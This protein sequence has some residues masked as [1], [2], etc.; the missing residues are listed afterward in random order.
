MDCKEEVGEGS[1]T[2]PAS[3]PAVAPRRVAVNPWFVAAV[4]A[5]VA[6]SAVASVFFQSKPEADLPE[7]RSAIET[8]PTS[9]PRSFALSPDGRQLAFVATADGV[10]RLWVRQLASTKAQPLTVTEGGAA[11]TFWSPDS[12]SIG[13]FSAGKLRTIDA[14]G[15]SPRIVAEARS[16]RGGT[17]NAE[18]V[19]LFAP[20]SASPLSRVPASGG[21]AVA[22]TK[23]NDTKGSHR[24][25]QFLP[26]GRHFLF[27]DEGFGTKLVIALGTLGSD[28]GKALTKADSAGLYMPPGWVLWVRAGIL[29]ARRL[30]IAR[31]ELTGDTLTVADPVTSDTSHARLFSVSETGVVTYRS[32]IP[33]TEIRWFD[34]SG[35][36]LGAFAEPT[37]DGYAPSVG[38]LSPDGRRIASPATCGARAITGSSTTRTPIAS[39]SVFLDGVARSGRPTAGRWRSTRSRW[40]RAGAFSAF[41]PRPPTV[42]EK[43]SRWG[44]RSE[45]CR[46]SNW[47][48][49]GK[50]FIYQ[51]I[52]PKTGR[53]LWTVPLGGDHKPRPFHQTKFDEKY[54]RFSPDGRWVAYTSNASGRTEIYVTP[55][56]GPAEG[57]I[58]QVS[59]DGGLFP[60]WLCDGKELYWIGPG[61]RMM[62]APIAVKGT[63]SSGETIESGAPVQLFQ[64][65][66]FNGGLDV[67]T[68][69][70]CAG[71]TFPD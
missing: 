2:L 61:G 27:Y 69:R 39:R 21:E 26:D 13:Y 52:D 48:P 54:G 37:K 30:D 64:A 11:Y 22:A 66:I 51:T 29:V 24:F 8:P 5:V 15:G 38:R 31:G 70:R 23:L 50:F 53:D 4:S 12:R 45:T 62:A 25:P 19:I 18:G 56:D 28:E 33:A 68:I 46:S 55:L 57:K 9:D 1:E 65:P 49:D 16:A 44:N 40:G 6:I 47:S 60:A 14:A 17:W 32:G 71:R 63:A 42:R 58:W 7:T 41:I 3:E 35:K 20:G 10:S 36:A 43:R 59:L 34:R 67:N